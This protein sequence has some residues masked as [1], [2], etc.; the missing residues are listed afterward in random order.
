MVGVI[1]WCAPNLWCDTSWLPSRSLWCT[2]L[3]QDMLKISRN[4]F[5]NHFFKMDVSI[6]IS[7]DINWKHR[8]SLFESTLGIKICICLHVRFQCAWE[9]H[10]SETWRGYLPFGLNYLDVFKEKKPRCHYIQNYDLR[11]ESIQFQNVK[12]LTTLLEREN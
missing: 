9:E 2:L 4:N 8:S 5:C 1:T 10:I 3:V 11:E 6:C 7:F 12:S